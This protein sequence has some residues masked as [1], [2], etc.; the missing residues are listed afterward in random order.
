MSKQPITYVVKK[1]KKYKVDYLLIE[2][3]YK[4]ELEL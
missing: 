1:K 2:D 3:D 4:V